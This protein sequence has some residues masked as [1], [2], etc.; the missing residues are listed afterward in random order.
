MKDKD[1]TICT[2]NFVAADALVKQVA[3]VSAV[4][5]LILFFQNIPVTSRKVKIKH[6]FDRCFL[7]CHHA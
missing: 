2:G 7:E 4:M 1:L 3:R 6:V 5:V